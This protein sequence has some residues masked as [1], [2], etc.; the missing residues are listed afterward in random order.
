MGRAEEGT[1]TPGRDKTST[2]V[3]GRSLRCCALRALRH[4]LVSARS[5]WSPRIR[6]RDLVL[7]NAATLFQSAREQV[8]IDVHGLQCMRAAHSL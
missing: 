1:G 7:R 3:G 4:A 5:P 6:S 2:A 8:N